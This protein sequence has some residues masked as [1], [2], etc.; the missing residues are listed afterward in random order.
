MT[1]VDWQQ[2][3]PEEAARRI[4]DRVASLPDAQRRAIFATIPTDG[5]LTA[6]FAGAKPGG[7]LRGVPYLLKD[8]FDVAGQ[9]TLAGSTFL[10]EVRP[11]S[12]RDSALV[13][14]LRAAGAVLAGKTHLHEFAFGLTGENPHY[15][16]CE[17][18]HFS[19]RTSGG[20]SSGSAA[21]VAAGIVPLAIGTDTGGSIRVPAA[22]C[23]LHGFRMTPHHAWISD[24]FPL[25]RSFDTAGWF[26][27]TAEDMRITLA[28]L[29]GPVSST[30]SSSRGCWM[31][32]PALDTEIASVFRTAASDI[33]PAVD[34]T[35]R[36]ALMIAFAPASEIY[37]ALGAHEAWAVHQ[38]WADRFKDRYDPVVWARLEKARVLPPEQM[39]SAR[40]KWEQLKKAWEEFFRN[41][42]FLL[43]PASPCVAL[44]KADC[45]AANRTRLLSLTAPVSLAGLPA[46]VIPIM[47]SSGL[48]TGLQIVARDSNSAIFRNLLAGAVA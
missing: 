10:P 22:F 38:S 40:L 2:L 3:A 44:T 8:V 25:A 34:D 17:H 19:R 9:P 23:G 43:L 42:D 37:G 12:S 1:F 47:L 5:E 31:E 7:V 27:R 14:T 15:G 20:S 35:M 33:A 29:L 16:D 45:T 18:P 28:A 46:M 13:Q 39:A 4:R 41:Y 36:Q 48:S 24:A 30:P 21:A 6:Q 26:T 32:L 11:T